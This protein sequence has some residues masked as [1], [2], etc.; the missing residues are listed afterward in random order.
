MTWAIVL[1]TSAYVGLAA[2][3]VNLQLAA[4]YGRWIKGACI[5]AATLFY[6]VA[7]N[8]ALGLVGWPSHD[9]PPD[10]FRLHAIW[11]EEPDPGGERAGA[12]YIWVR[13]LDEEGSPVGEPRA[14]EMPWTRELAKTMH[15]AQEEMKEGALLD[16]SFTEEESEALEG[17]ARGEGGT[18]T[19]G[20]LRSVPEDERSQFDFR[21]V[22]RPTL[23]PKNTPDGL[24][25]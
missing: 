15:G 25:G 2:L 6:G 8:G 16:G 23:P 5:A 20:P 14:F 4:P 1:L 9:L 10:D 13:D 12:I 17:D 3:L 11:M 19:D 18:D 21:R 22:E 24:E 7:W